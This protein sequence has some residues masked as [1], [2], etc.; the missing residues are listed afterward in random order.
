MFLSFTLT[1]PRDSSVTIFLEI[2]KADEAKDS[3]QVVYLEAVFI[4]T[5]VMPVCSRMTVNDC[6]GNYMST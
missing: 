5:A 3:L 4:H 1:G 2:T 6:G